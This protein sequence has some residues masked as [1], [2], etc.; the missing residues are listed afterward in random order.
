MKSW[1][2]GGIAIAL[3]TCT[4]ALG[5]TFYNSYGET[6]SQSQYQSQYSPHYPSQSQSQYSPQYQYQSPYSPHYPSQYQHRYS[7][8]APAIY[9]APA[10]SSIVIYRS[11]SYPNR[12]GFVTNPYRQSVPLY[13]AA[14]IYGYP[15]S[16]RSNSIR[17]NLNFGGISVPRRSRSWQTY[18]SQTIYSAPNSYGGQYPIYGRPYRQ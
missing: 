4:P 6:I 1:M 13:P 2:I 11:S 12:R 10:S 18:P 16:N 17:L 9:V 5:Q 8:Q 14:S 7:P 15:S 3:L